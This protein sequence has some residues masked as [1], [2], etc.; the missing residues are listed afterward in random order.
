V[1][2][3]EGPAGELTASIAHEINQ[4][5]ASILTNTETA[6]LITQS[7]TPDMEEISEILAD[8]RFSV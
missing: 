3:F 4:P 1:R 5:L 2:L 8:I 6:E 7:A